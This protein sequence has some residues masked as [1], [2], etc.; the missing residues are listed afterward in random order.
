MFLKHFILAFI[1]LFSSGCTVL[2]VG[3]VS[4]IGGTYYISGEIK[5]SYSTSIYNLYKI[6]LHVLKEENIK[7]I[8]VENTK[9]DADILAKFPDTTSIKMHI[10]YNKEGFATIGIRVGVIGNEKRSRG[11]LNKMEKYL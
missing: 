8:S 11:L 7:V 1:L 3:V 10:Y 2:G 5:S 9:T 4:A 6:S